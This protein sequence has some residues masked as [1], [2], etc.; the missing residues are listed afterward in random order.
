MSVFRK[1]FT[2]QR[3]LE[4]FHIRGHRVVEGANDTSADYAWLCVRSKEPTR[5]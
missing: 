4:G 5:S 3:A 1:V 2:T